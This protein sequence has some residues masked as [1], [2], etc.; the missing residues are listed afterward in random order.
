LWAGDRGAVGRKD[1]ELRLPCG[2]RNLQIAV[3]ADDAAIKDIESPMLRRSIL[4]KNDA[5]LLIGPPMFP[6]Y[7]SEL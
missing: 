2:T 7:C 4:K 1:R 6:L 3:P 5:F